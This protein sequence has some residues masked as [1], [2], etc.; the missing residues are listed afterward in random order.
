VTSPSMA[1][2]KIDRNEPPRLGRYVDLRGV[3]LAGDW[4]RVSRA[5]DAA[6]KAAWRRRAG[7]VRTSSAGAVQAAPDRREPSS[8]RAPPPAYPRSLTD[9]RPHAPATRSTWT[10]PSADAPVR[11]SQD[12][13]AVDSHSPGLYVRLYVHRST[14]PRRRRPRSRSSGSAPVA[15]GPLCGRAPDR[16]DWWLGR[17]GEPVRA[18]VLCVGSTA[19]LPERPLAQCG[20]CAGS[21]TRDCPPVGAVHRYAG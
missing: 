8:W 3:E 9:L 14:V 1:V 10:T 11:F 4:T 18:H 21:S 16:G 15:A 13:S 17:V 5:R 19:S 6:S 7:S 12:P 20:L 2:G